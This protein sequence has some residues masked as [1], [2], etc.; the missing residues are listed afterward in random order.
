M[1]RPKKKTEDFL[2]S[3][4]KNSETLV[5]QAHRKPEEILEFVTTNN[6]TK[7]NT[8]FQSTS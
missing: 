3:I 4:T 1:I 8:S 5:E 6:Q 2:L 7:K